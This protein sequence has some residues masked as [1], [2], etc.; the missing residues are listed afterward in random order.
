MEYFLEHAHAHRSMVLQR[1]STTFTNPMAL[2][3][4]IGRTR[5]EPSIPNGKPHTRTLIIGY[6]AADQT[7]Q[8]PIFDEDLMEGEWIRP[9]VRLRFRGGFTLVQNPSQTNNA[10]IIY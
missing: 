2:N 7:S 6:K 3:Q 5:L 4:R 9:N 10:F 1:T 8:V